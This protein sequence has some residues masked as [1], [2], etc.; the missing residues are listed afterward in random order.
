MP[1]WITLSE[2]AS[3]CGVT[4]GAVQ[5]A[6]ASGRVSAVKRENGRLVAIDWIEGRE[7]W[8]TNTDPLQAARRGAAMVHGDDARED[9]VREI[10]QEIERED[11]AEGADAQSYYA[12]RTRREIAQAR[13]AELALARELGEVVSAA[14]IK[15]AQ[16]RRYRAVRDK[17]LGLADRLAP[18][19]AVLGDARA[20]YDTLRRAIKETL[21]ELAD[22]AH[23]ELIDARGQER[24]GA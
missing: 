17:L 12:A 4:H 20:V 16:Y 21:V 24:A 1:E 23:D 22:G 10:A 7:Q 13:Q 8:R 9:A 5:K 6:V 3:R 19:L 15:R 2:F 18:E 11:G 14:E